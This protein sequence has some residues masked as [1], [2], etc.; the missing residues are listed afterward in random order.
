MRYVIQ[1]GQVSSR[2]DFHR[3]RGRNP[4]AVTQKCPGYLRNCPVMAGLVLFHFREVLRKLG[5]DIFEGWG[6]FILA[7]H[8]YNALLKE[9]MITQRWRDMELVMRFLQPESFF[10]GKI[11]GKHSEYFNN[12][13]LRMGISAASLTNAMKQRHKKGKF[14][15]TELRPLGDTT[16]VTAMFRPR[17]VEAMGQVNWMPEH[18]DSVI[19]KSTREKPTDPQIGFDDESDDEDA[20]ETPLDTSDEPLIGKTITIRPDGTISSVESVV[21]LMTARDNKDDR[22][23]WE[24]PEARESETTNRQEQAPNHPLVRIPQGVRHAAKAPSAQDA[25][26]VREEEMARHHKTASEG[27]LLPLSVLVEHLARALNAEVEVANIPLVSFHQIC[28]DFMTKVRNRCHEALTEDWGQLHGRGVRPG[29]DGRVRPALRQREGRPPPERRGNPRGC[30]GVPGT[31]R[32]AVAAPL[33][34]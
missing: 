13:C 17:Y 10:V 19:S 25:F 11:P 18:V 21:I 23:D 4:P 28:C 32:R 12:F 27:G 22:D 33:L 7:T 8:L 2:A 29:L 5:T 3:K 34:G 9:N 20:E 1:G 15:R 24:P 30:E 6:S 26:R 16:P 14:A 31:V